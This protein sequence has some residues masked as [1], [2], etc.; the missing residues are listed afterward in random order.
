M[1][2]HISNSYE[3][4]IT[5]PIV[6]V[7]KR[8][9]RGIVLHWRGENDPHLCYI[10]ITEDDGNWFVSSQPVSSHWISEDL[11]LII[12]AREWMMANAF[13]DVYD[14]SFYGWTMRGN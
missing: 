13:E 5:T 4:T 3:E 12:K 14:Q 8:G 9:C 2:T 7:F 1:P 11:E 6:K 10:Y